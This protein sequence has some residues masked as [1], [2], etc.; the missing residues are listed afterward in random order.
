M[1]KNYLLDPCGAKPI[2]CELYH[3][4]SSLCLIHNI[5]PRPQIIISYLTPTSLRPD[6]Q[7]TV[8][9]D[10][11]AAIKSKDFKSSTWVDSSAF[12]SFQKLFCSLKYLKKCQWV[13]LL[14]NWKSWIKYSITKNHKTVLYEQKIKKVLGKIPSLRIF[15]KLYTRHV[16]ITSPKL[17]FYFM[18][19][20]SKLL[21]T[22]KLFKSWSG[23]SN[24]YLLRNS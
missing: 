7:S 9:E 4:K 21:T 20:T 17:T 8:I 11:K 3:F 10:Q 2:R 15:R 13:A 1:Q 14:R 23:S 16:V 22:E 6:S 24:S 12:T 19:P 5:G 18:V